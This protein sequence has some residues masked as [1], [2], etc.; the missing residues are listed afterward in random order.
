MEGVEAEVASW[1]ER[2]QSDVRITPVVIAGMV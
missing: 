1:V 2:L